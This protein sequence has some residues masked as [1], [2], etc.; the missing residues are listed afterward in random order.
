MYF[1]VG[2]SLL[3]QSI[4]LRKSW[5]KLIERKLRHDEMNDKEI[6]TFKKNLLLFMNTEIS[7]NIKRLLP[8]DLKTI[9]S[10]NCD[11]F[12]LLGNV[13][14][15]PFDEDFVLSKNYKLGGINVTEYVIYNC[16]L[17]EEW[18]NAIENQIL[19]SPLECSNCHV[20]DLGRSML[21]IF[22]HDKLC[23]LRDTAGQPNEKEKDDS[24]ITTKSNSKL[25]QCKVCKSDLYLT[26]IEILRHSKSCT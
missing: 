16:L 24:H 3:F 8:A 2:K 20:S 23:I 11:N 25:F 9:F 1:P 19:H 4:T 14:Q 10:Y 26:S 15:N 21:Q 22:H 17:S 12:D 7:Y 13:I 5:K 6:F 18:D